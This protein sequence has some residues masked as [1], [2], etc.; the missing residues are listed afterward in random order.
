MVFETCIKHAARQ[1]GFR[2][3]RRA[4]PMLHFA[5]ASPIIPIASTSPRP[6]RWKDIEMNPA[7]L[8][9]DSEAMLQGLRGWVE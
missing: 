7:N 3:G 1:S 5:N 4:A 8:P 9:F 6:L 2:D